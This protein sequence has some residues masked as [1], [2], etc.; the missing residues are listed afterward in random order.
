MINLYFSDVASRNIV[1][2]K[3]PNMRKINQ[4]KIGN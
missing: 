2:F 3:M 1:Q 4:K